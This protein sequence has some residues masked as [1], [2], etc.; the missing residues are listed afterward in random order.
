MNSD[1]K[2]YKGDNGIP[3]VQGTQV[4]PARTQLAPVNMYGQEHTF[5]SNDH[6]RGEK[7]PK[8]CNDA[9][10]A[11]FFIAHLIS[12]VVLAFVYVPQLNGDGGD[13]R[14]LMES[15]QHTLTQAMT[16]L[17][18]LIESK[19]NINIP[20]MHRGLEDGGY[21]AD[22]TSVM[23][24]VSI[25]V[26]I[27]FFVSI[28][29]LTVMI[30]FAEGLIKFS[31]VFNV[32]LGL[33]TAMAGFA[34]Q[35]T[36][37]GVMGLILFGISAF[38]ACMIWSRI[39][40]AAT[41]L[42]TA[43]TAIK[44][45]L[46]VVTFAYG[47]LILNG[48][49][50]VFWSFTTYATIYV[51]GD[52]DAD[53]NCQNEI[54]GFLVAALILSLYWTMQVIKNVLH[55]TVAGTVGTW[56][57]APV[58]AN[59]IC[60]PAVTESHNRAL[61]HSFGSICFGSLLVAIV[62][63]IRSLCESARDGDDGLCSCIAICLLGILES[64]MEMFNEWAFVYVG[65]YGYSFIDAAKNV[66]TLFKSRGWTAI[67]TDYIVDRVLTMVSFGTGLFTGAVAAFIS[68]LFGL[69]L[70]GAAF[71]IGFVVA[72]ILTS[73]VLGVVGSGVNT[74]V[75]CYAEDPKAFEDNHHELSVRMR[76]SW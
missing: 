56:W 50:L 22:P 76:E 58:G 71:L 55:V 18:S 52:C 60:S 7:Q 1:Y 14:N 47:A 36:E 62:Q 20:S 59:S 73:I 64:L 13:R 43:S 69:N 29:S 37:A 46:G 54:N 35:S 28:L 21:D 30:Q 49:W 25:S 12:L 45:N 41:N 48:V 8:K 65:L 44:A 34:A 19:L 57:W 72:F 74:V 70:E 4:S 67:I 23:I 61:T 33:L 32:L 24:V 66:I 6:A 9:F 42:V 16:S 27:A 75:V 2:Q 5:P 63:T 39:P 15:G 40:F 10:F 3:V 31:L 26:V 11:C 38:Y 17:Q 68:Y 53:G 51:V